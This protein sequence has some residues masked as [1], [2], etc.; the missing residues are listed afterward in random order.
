[1]HRMTWV[2]LALVAV[3][4]AG[5]TISAV[6]WM[7][8]RSHRGPLLPLTE[9]EDLIRIG[10][11]RH[12]R[13]LA[14]DI[15]E[16]HLWHEGSMAAAADYVHA[17]FATAGLAVSEQRFTVRGCEVA[18][19]IGEA[20]PPHPDGE[21]VVVGAHYDSVIGTVGANDNASGVAVLLEL[22]RL[23]GPRPLGRQLRF[24]AFAN[25]EPPFFLSWE[26]GSRQYA[27]RCRERRERLVA[28]L[29]LETMGCYS[30]RRFSQSYPFPFGLFYP[31]T[32][33]FIAF[34]GNLRSRAL[35]RRCLRSFRGHAAFPSEGTAAP[36]YLPGVFWSDHWAFWREGYQALMVTDTALFRY[37]YYH[38]AGDT[39]EKIDYARLARVVGGLAHV[40]EDLAGGG[41]DSGVR[42]QKSEVGGETQDG[43]RQV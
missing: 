1:M 20:G 16:R 40:I 29:A 6:T 3:V 2:A 17:A 11:R 12:V 28:M 34:V 15:G 37:G 26:M 33:N 35:V 7:P 5:V 19:V 4:A 42:S 32:G 31:R 13:T 14:S 9:A 43:G 10:L 8:G 30:D 18:N 27:R 22:A 25:E 36:G 21:L 39:P 23:L 38:L 24:V 41:E